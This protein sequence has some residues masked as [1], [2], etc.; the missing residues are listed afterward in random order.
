MPTKATRISVDSSKR[1]SS[2]R[3]RKNSGVV[4][5]YRFSDAEILP[6][7]ETGLAASLR[8][9][10]RLFRGWVSTIDFPATF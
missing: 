3:L 4:S 2:N 9:I 7:V 8:E 6:P 10:N 5:G 1:I